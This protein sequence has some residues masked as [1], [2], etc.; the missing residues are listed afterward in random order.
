MELPW[1]RR[2]CSREG[3][4]IARR[5]WPRGCVEIIRRR[6]GEPALESSGDPRHGVRIDSPTYQP[7]TRR[8]VCTLAFLL[9]A[10]ALAQRVPAEEPESLPTAEEA[11]SQPS[12]EITDDQRAAALEGFDT[13][14]DG[15]ISE[16]EAEEGLASCEPARR[17]EEEMHRVRRLADACTGLQG[18]LVFK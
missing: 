2:V 9:A 18:F 5:L 15:E 7:M 3:Q 8:I 4:G 6:F 1:W 14:G 17:N 11:E 12:D 16:A 10:P 13:D